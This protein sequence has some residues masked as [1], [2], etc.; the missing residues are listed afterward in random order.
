MVH[1]PTALTAVLL[2][3]GMAACVTEAVRAQRTPARDRYGDPLPDGALA[4]LGTLRWRHGGVTGFVAFLPDG[5]SILS[6]SDDQVFH[7]WDYPSGKKL[8]Q[9]GPGTRKPSRFTRRPLELSYATGLPVALSPDGQT[10]ACSFERGEL[11]LFDTATGEKLAALK[12]PGDVSKLQFSPDGRCL[13]FRDLQGWLSIWDWANRKEI[14]RRPINVQEIICDTSVLTYSPDGKLLATVL[15][16]EDAGGDIVSTIKLLDP[17]TGKD[18]G[19]IKAATKDA[20]VTALVIS[21]DSKLLAYT[22]DADARTCLLDIATRNELR[23]IQNPQSHSGPL[24]F[25]PDGKSLFTLS[26]LG[27]ELQEWEVRTGKKLRR[28]PV[29]WQPT[30]LSGQ[31]TRTPLAL[32]LDRQILACAGGDHLIYFIDRRNGKSEPSAGSNR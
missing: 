9:F 6:A 7:L 21:P 18:V 15:S 22:T 32:S 29:P 23:W 24:L 10:L 1:M 28:F 17:L 16:D 2:S 11:L 31:M 5:K 4:R 26:W 20:L 27:A 14:V 8:R 30:Q 3:L 25:A 19:A 12:P 13:A